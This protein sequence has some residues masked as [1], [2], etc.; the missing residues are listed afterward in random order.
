MDDLL[1]K[2]Y[3]SKDDYKYLKPCGSKPDIMYG[4]CKIHKGTTVNVPV[5]LFRPI[6]SVIG[7]CNYNTAKHFVPVLK[8][9][10]INEY[11]FTDSF[12]F[13]KEILDQDPNLFMALL[14]KL[15]QSLFTNIRLDERINICVDLVFHKKKKVK[16]M[17]KR[18]FKQLLTLS[19]KLYCFL[20]NDVYYK[21]VDSVAIG[22]PL[23]STL[24][25]LFLVYYEH[26]W[27]E[28]CPLRFRPK[29]YRR[30]IGYIFLMFKG[31]GHVKK[32]LKYMNS[33]HPNIQF[34]CE[35]ESNNKISFLDISITRINNKSATSL[36]RKKTF[37][38]V[39]LNFNS[40]LPMDYKK[41]LIH[42]LL[43]RAHNICADYTT[44]HNKFEFLKSIY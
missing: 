22:S 6:L 19:V 35:E 1:D 36:C 17:L 11:T 4:L 13:C 38:G 21:Q 40:F 20:F 44:L 33:H 39:Y 7:T 3:L 24:V 18:H 41:C 25:N 30:Y 28:N 29:Y 27:L 23:G 14:F 26:K 12:S 37:N 10:T 15:F 5:P 43:F 32:F 31:R 34:I 2:N 16:V 42:N 8:Q 9:F